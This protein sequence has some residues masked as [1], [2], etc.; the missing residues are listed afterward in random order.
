MGVLSQIRLG[1]GVVMENDLTVHIE[2]D[3]SQHPF[4]AL[5]DDDKKFTHTFSTVRQ[6]WVDRDHDRKWDHMGGM[7]GQYEV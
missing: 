3:E 5:P 6:V 4:R 1:E 2:T 7:R